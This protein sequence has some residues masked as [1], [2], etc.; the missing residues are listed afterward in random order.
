MTAGFS[1][2]KYL[3]LIVSG[4]AFPNRLHPLP[5]SDDMLTSEPK[6]REFLRNDPLRTVGVST[7]FLL[8][9]SRLRGWVHTR[10]PELK[11][12]LLTLLAERD[13]VV[14]NGGIQSWLGRTRAEPNLVRVYPEARH[15]LL[16]EPC[17]EQVLE[18]I[19]TFVSQVEAS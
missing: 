19:E 17:K 6:S 16:M 4:F 10:A 8:N 14:D 7:R 2:M 1:K 15:C 9:V 18:D 13:Q 11:L 5:I 3:D 12:P